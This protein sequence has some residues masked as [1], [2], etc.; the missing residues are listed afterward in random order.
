L[1]SVQLAF[2]IFDDNT[3][4]P[5]VRWEHVNSFDEVQG[6]I[7]VYPRYDWTR[8]STGIMWAWDKGAFTKFQYAEDHTELNGMPDTKWFGLA[9]GF[10]IAKFN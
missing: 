8:K 4:V 9:F 2:D 5:Y 10:D 3:L 7:P 1:D 6:S